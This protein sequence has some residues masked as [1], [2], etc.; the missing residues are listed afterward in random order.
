MATYTQISPDGHRQEVKYNL[1]HDGPVSHRLTLFKKV[2]YLAYQVDLRPG[3][4][5]LANKLR[6][7]QQKLAAFD[8]SQRKV[9]SKKSHEVQNLASRYEHRHSS[10]DQPHSDESHERLGWHRNRS[11]SDSAIGLGLPANTPGQPST[12]PLEALFGYQYPL[13]PIS[14]GLPSH[15]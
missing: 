6:Q 3:D 4:Y 13:E 15:G 14:I 2:K 9:S 11:A 7:A 1:H 10:Q 5:F 8:S 12:P